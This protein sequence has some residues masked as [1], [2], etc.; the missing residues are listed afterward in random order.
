MVKNGK[1]LETS[2][3]VVLLYILYFLMKK[4]MFPGIVRKK[5]V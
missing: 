2:V 5:Y 1:S 4:E 3:R